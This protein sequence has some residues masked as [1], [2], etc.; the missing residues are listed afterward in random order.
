[1]NFFK[2]VGRRIAGNIKKDIDYMKGDGANEKADLVYDKIKTFFSGGWN[3]LIDKVVNLLLKSA[4]KDIK[5]I[6]AQCK[7]HGLD[8][9]DHFPASLKDKLRKTSYSR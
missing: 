5:A 7:S 4:E 3:I 6:V 9:Y 1:M 8:P 2:S